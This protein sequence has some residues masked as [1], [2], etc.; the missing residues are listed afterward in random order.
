[1]PRVALIGDSHLTDTSPRAVVKLGPRLRRLGYD[2]LTLARGGLDSRQALL[3][4][5]AIGVGWAI[6]SFGTND[7]APWKQIPPDEFA[8]NYA[9]LLARTTATAQLVLGLPPVVESERAGGR[10]NALVREYTQIASRTA[11]EYGATFLALSD[12]LDA[13][14][15]ADDGVHLNDNGYST[16]TRLV[17]AVLHTPTSQIR[18][19]PAQVE[20]AQVPRRAPD[21]RTGHS[22]FPFE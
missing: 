2:V 12:H 15:L 18:V 5:P 7:A 21:R 11:R 8:E 14:D 17:A 3:D 1:M 20:P 22:S 4:P 6:Y 10:T 16:V 9:T 13:A 19:K